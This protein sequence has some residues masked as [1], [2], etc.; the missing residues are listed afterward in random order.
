M[1]RWLVPIARRCV[2][3][4]SLG[5]LER[6]RDYVVQFWSRKDGL[7]AFLRELVS[8]RAEAVS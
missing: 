5:Y 7:A 3:L 4:L 2:Q 8:F 6:D 1:T